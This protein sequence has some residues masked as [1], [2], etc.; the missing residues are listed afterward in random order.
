MDLSLEM[1]GVP[2]AMSMDDFVMWPWPGPSLSKPRH[3]S[4]SPDLNLPLFWPR[5]APR[6]VASHAS[7]PN[8]CL[9]IFPAVLALSHE[10]RKTW[11]CN[12]NVCAHLVIQVIHILVICD[13][14]KSHTQV[15]ICVCMTMFMHNWSM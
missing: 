6:G 4:Q 7:V 11:A 1:S 3:R 5:F 14:N 15:Y 10:P 12:G 8:I 13:A 9:N 2:I